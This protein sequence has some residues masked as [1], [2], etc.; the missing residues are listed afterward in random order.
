MKSLKKIAAMGALL[1]AVSCMGI[2]AG[3]ESMAERNE[4]IA[5]EIIEMGVDPIKPENIAQTGDNYSFHIEAGNGGILQG[6]GEGAD[7]PFLFENLGKPVKFG[8]RVYV[9]GI[10]QDFYVGETGHGGVFSLG[11]GEKLETVLH[12]ERLELDGDMSGETVPVSI[13]MT[14]MNEDISFMP[15]SRL[16]LTIDGNEVTGENVALVGKSH[17]ITEREDIRFSVGKDF[18]DNTMGIALVPQGS[19]RHMNFL[20]PSSEDGV[21]K[22]EVMGWSTFEETCVYRLSAY[23]NGERVL[24]NGEDEYVDV[25]LKNGMMTSADV[26]LEADVGDRIELVAVPLGNGKMRSRVSRFDVV[27]T[28]D[29][30]DDLPDDQYYYPVKLSPEQERIRYEQILAAVADYENGV[31]DETE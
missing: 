7:I 5:A 27:N 6:T 28:E 13:V 23:K 16:Q 11:M 30:P 29:I 25:T 10:E 3:A 18:M 12:I 2:S 14:D 19:D 15:E 22:L 8:L 26:T 24:W 1:T 17:I 20:L 31:M 4:R 9:S 21:L